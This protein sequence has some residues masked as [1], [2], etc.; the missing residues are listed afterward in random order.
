MTDSPRQTILELLASKRDTYV[1]GQEISD[2]LGFSRTSVW[3]HIQSL[4][5]KGYAIDSTPNQGYRLKA[6]PDDLIPEEILRNLKTECFGKKIVFYPEVDST[7]TQA[8]KQATEYPEGTIFIAERQT[9]GRGRLGRQWSSSPQKGIWCSVLLKPSIR[10]TDASL[11]PLITA[12]AI[13]EALQTI[14]IEVSIKWPNDLLLA[15][16]K[17]CGILT[18][19]ASDPD[20]INYLVLGF[21]LNVKHQCA[22][23]PEEIQS[24]ATSLELATGQMINRVQLLCAILYRIEQNYHKFLTEGFEPIRQVWIEHTCTLGREAKI[25]RFNQPP[26][27]GKALDLNPDGTL[28]L[29]LPD[30]TTTPIISGEIPLI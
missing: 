2:K 19:M 21:G 30:G 4:R 13:T 8:K 6:V 11:F 18:E 12:V 16:K 28:L 9:G 17:I 29:E 15:G 24:I 10:P 26:L 23:F 20:Q 5:E 25:S 3:K 7:N 14:G 27:Y 22:D 1:S